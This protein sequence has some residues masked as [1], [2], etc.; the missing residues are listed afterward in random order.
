MYECY[1][2]Y[3]TDEVYPYC[4]VEFFRNKEA[5]EEYVKNSNCNTLEVRHEKW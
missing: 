4:Y 5:A 3:D 2:V 1:Y